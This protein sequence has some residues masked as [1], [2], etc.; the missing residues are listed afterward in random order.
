M[1]IAIYVFFYQT[2]QGV[3]LL[4]VRL[5]HPFGVY[6]FCCYFYNHISPSGLNGFILLHAPNLTNFFIAQ[7][8]CWHLPNPAF[9]MGCL[10]FNFGQSSCERSLFT[11]LRLIRKDAEYRCAIAFRTIEIG[12]LLVIITRRM[13]EYKPT[14]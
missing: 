1:S 9:T 5:C 7:I 10:C 8:V 13:F 6:F 14:L 3:I 11:F 4:T 2:P 12:M